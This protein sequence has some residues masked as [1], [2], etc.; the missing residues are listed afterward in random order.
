MSGKPMRAVSTRFHTEDKC[1]D[2]V[3]PPKAPVEAL[4]GGPGSKPSLSAAPRG[5][6]G[7]VNFPSPLERFT[8]LS[9]SLRGSVALEMLCILLHGRVFPHG[10]H[11]LVGGVL[12]AVLQ[13]F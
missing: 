13:Y 2:L 3:P 11:L 9:G 1:G 10:G 8:L 6:K 12:W 4:S 5:F 7:G